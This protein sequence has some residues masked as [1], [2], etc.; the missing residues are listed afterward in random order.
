MTYSR[1]QFNSLYNLNVCSTI[2]RKFLPN[3][4]LILFSFLLDTLGPTYRI[5]YHVIFSSLL[6]IVTRQSSHP[7]LLTPWTTTRRRRMA[8]GTMVSLTPRRFER[9]QRR[10]HTGTA[11]EQVVRSTDP[12]LRHSC[13]PCCRRYGRAGT[14]ESPG[15]ALGSVRT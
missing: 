7:S 3:F 6:S 10:Q 15:S 4:Y 8:T 2:Y 14:C 9:R 11:D 5:P 1:T 13:R 12:S